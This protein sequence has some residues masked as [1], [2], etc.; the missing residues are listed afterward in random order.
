MLHIL[1]KVK[2]VIMSIIDSIRICNA[3][4]NESDIILIY[5]L[6]NKINYKKYYYSLKPS[7]SFLSAKYWA[8][9][10][11]NLAGQS[12]VGINNPDSSCVT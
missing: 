11:N 5:F 1:T 12:L 10:S 8:I 2:I 7:S 9:P 3:N 4:S 6:I